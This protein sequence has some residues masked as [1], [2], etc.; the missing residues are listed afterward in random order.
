VLCSKNSRGALAWVDSRLTTPPV[1]WGAGQEVGQLLEGRLL[2]SATAVF[3]L[4][5]GY[6]GDQVF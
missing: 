1:N 5:R 4:A 2:E 6:L 3:A